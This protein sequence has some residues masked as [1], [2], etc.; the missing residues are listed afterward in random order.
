MTTFGRMRHAYSA[1][2]LLARSVSSN[3]LR[4]D[5]QNQ[6]DLLTSCVMLLV[7]S[8]LLVAVP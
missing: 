5:V 8:V 7:D 2:L 4:R 3:L 6:E 1:C